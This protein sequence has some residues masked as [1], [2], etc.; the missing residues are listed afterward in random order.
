MIY[1]SPLPCCFLGYACVIVFIRFSLF[2]FRRSFPDASGRYSLFVL[3]LFLSATA[4]CY[5]ITIF[6]FTI[7][8]PAD[9]ST[10]YIPACSFRWIVVSWSL[11]SLCSTIRP[12]ASKMRM[13]PSGLNPS[14]MRM[15]M[16]PW[17]LL[18]I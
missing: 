8:F 4:E 2:V 7:N 14:S 1:V 5:S 10:K 11:K 18:T 17:L 6:L 9:T 12:L 15:M 3:F 16:V 13:L